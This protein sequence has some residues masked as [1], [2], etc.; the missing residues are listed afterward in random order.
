ML[1]I[2]FV[3]LGNICRSPMAE[4]IFAD[5]VKKEN[6]SDKISVSSCGTSDEEQGNPL[7]YGAKAK[8]TEMG[9]PFST[10]FAHKITDSE[11]KNA[12]ML[13]TMEMRNSV[14]L[15]RRFGESEKVCTLLSFC[16]GGDIA[17]PWY[18]GNFDDTYTD[19][20]N[21]CSALLK[22]IKENKL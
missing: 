12:D 11:Y 19:I 16:G 21:G 4:F 10:H 1:N 9:I 2:V 6:L 13:I 15:N 8:L 7:H 22:Y 18:T 20:I 5:M 3:C 14:S 17:D